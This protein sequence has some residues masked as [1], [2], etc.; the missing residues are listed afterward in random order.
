[1]PL[2]NYILTFDDGTKDHYDYYKGFAQ[3]D[4]QKIYFISSN[5][6][7]L[8]NYMTIDEIKE[9]ML[10]ESVSIGGHS[11]EHIKLDNMS[12]LES[13]KHI[14]KDTQ[15]M[16]NWFNKNLGFKPT[17]FCYPF[18]NDLNKVYTAMM[19]RQ[20][21]TDFYGCERIPIEKLLRIQSQTEN[22]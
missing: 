18:N 4:T 21:I 20:G 6:V 17:K 14:E 2:E 19:K 3:F 11:H 13:V 9:L 15:L 16:F 22:L 1:M 8:E 12:L 5:L 7:G 10:D